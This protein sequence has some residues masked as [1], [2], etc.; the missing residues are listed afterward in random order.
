[1]DKVIR[2]EKFNGEGYAMW[3][4][5]MKAALVVQ[6]LWDVVELDMKV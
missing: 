1:M 6:D 4:A 5:K 2:L 3:K